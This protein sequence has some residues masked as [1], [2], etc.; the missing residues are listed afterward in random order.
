MNKSLSIMFLSAVLVW[1]SGCKEPIIDEGILPFSEPATVDAD[2]GNWRT[3]VL[4]SAAAINVPQPDAVTSDAYK[5]EFAQVR[6]GV[7]RLEPEKI[8]AINYW[9]VGGVKRWNQI[10]RLLVAKYSVESGNPQEA[11]NSPVSAPFAARLYA[12]LSVAQ[13]DA[14]VVAWRAKYQYNR[15]SLLDQ[16]V[17][18]RLPIAN[19]PSYP[20]EDAAIAEVSC[21]MLAYFFPNETAWLKTKATEHKQSRIWNGANVPSDIKGGEDLGAAVTAKVIDRVK[22]DRFSVANDPNNTWTNVLAK[23]PYDVKWSSLF[24]PARTPVAPLAGNVKTWLDST[25]VRKSLT[26]VPPATTSATFQNDLNEVRTIASVRTREQSRIAGKWDDGVGTYTIPGHWNL[27]AEEYIQQYRQNELRAARTY[28]LVNRALQDGGTACWAAKYTYFV[29]RPSQIDPTI[30]TATIIPN[31]PAYPS[32]QA[33]FASAATA[34]LLYLFPD[35]ATELNA[36]VTEATQAELYS[37]T[38][39]RFANEEGSRLGTA[40][41][42]LAVESAKGDGAK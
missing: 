21:Q 2:G 17:T 8:T 1:V 18:T 26:S 15:P 40:V 34:V 7:A 13:Y 39:Y 22:N 5:S 28:A 30:R 27:I 24:I 37:G 3:I 14:M 10:A 35:E 42:K 19:V 31:T 9:A 41:G 12:A 25:A 32:E 4:P 33:T 20:S 6:N 29:P 36:Q 11:T 38:A 16:G 23:A